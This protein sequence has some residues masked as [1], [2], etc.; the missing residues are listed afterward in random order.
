MIAYSEV[1]KYLCE[2]VHYILL[3]SV[4]H[5][6]Q[7]TVRGGH[8]LKT[9]LVLVKTFLAFLGFLLSTSETKNLEFTSDL[10]VRKLQIQICTNPVILVILDSLK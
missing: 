10:A 7:A 3:M 9:W 2:N 1:S 4:H 6:A 8:P 5:Y